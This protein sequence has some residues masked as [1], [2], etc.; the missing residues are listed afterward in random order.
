MVYDNALQ[1]LFLSFVAQITIAGRFDQCT[2]D[3]RIIIIL[4]CP[5]LFAFEKHSEK[6][7]YVSKLTVNENIPLERYSIYSAAGGT[8]I[9]CT[10][11]VR[12]LGLS[13]AVQ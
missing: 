1:L 4:S 6:Q 5:L 9:L 7:F 10:H 12:L 2:R 13:D 11:A 3:N 8:H